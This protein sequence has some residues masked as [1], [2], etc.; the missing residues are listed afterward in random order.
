MRNALIGLISLVML[1]GGAM[2]QSANDFVIDNAQELAT[3]CSTPKSSPNHTAAMSYCYGYGHGAYQYYKA[4]SMAEGGS[5]FIC[6]PK[7][8]PTRAEAWKGY[9][10]WLKK[11]PQYA[12]GEAIDV[13]F[14]YLGTAFPC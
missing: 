12:N 13:F 8:P 3:M 5:K 2:A 10:A 7:N 6:E 11:N 1:S 9:I 4:Q 14:R